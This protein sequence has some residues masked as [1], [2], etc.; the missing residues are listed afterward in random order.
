MNDSNNIL[1]S[2]SKISHSH[3]LNLTI[4]G[5]CFLPLNYKFRFFYFSTSTACSLSFFHVVCSLTL[6][7]PLTSVTSILHL[8]LSFLFIHPEILKPLPQLLFRQYSQFSY[9]SGF[10]VHPYLCAQAFQCLRAHLTSG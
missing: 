2:C 9:L 7:N 1:S 10:L 6:S 8:F 5:V 4:T 3:I